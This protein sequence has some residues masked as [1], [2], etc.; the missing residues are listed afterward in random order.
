VF[1]LALWRSS[2]RVSTPRACPTGSTF[3]FA[4][5]PCVP[6]LPRGLI[7]I[8]YGDWTTASLDYRL[9]WHL[10]HDIEQLAEAVDAAASRGIAKCDTIAFRIVQA[11]EEIGRNK[12]SGS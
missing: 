11:W 3:A 6:F 7:F 1:W 10:N 5:I 8:P 4:L 2:L 9:R 12:R